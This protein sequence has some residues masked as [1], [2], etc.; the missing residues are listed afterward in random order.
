[1]R[2]QLPDTPILVTTNGDALR[3]GKYTTPN[4][5]AVRDRLAITATTRNYAFWDFHTI[6]GGEASIREW[7]KHGLARPDH[8]HLTKKGYQLAGEL[9]FDALM[10]GY[11]EDHGR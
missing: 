4:N 6:M 5:A 9:L 8:I 10:K 2:V 3:K 1:M 7:N 11:G